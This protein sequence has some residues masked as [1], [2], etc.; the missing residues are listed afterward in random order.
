MPRL[1]RYGDNAWEDPGPEFSNDDVRKQLATYFPE[2][3]NA[4]V[5]T[6]ELPD[7][8]TEVL[9]VKRSGT[10]G[11]GPAEI[12]PQMSRP[13]SPGWIAAQLAKVKPAT[14]KAPGLLGRLQ[15]LDARGELDTA[16][17]LAAQPDLERATS[18]LSAHVEKSKEVA[19]RCSRLPACPGRSAPAGF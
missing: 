1:F 6:S 13:L 18:E 8:R 11:G 12:T 9:F 4:D 3:A 5:K 17:L 2:L 7:G 19:R 14:L 10:K 15:D 16:T